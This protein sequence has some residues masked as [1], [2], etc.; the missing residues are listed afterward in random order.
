METNTC[1]VNH[2]DADAHLPPRKRLLAGLK[3]QNLD[4]HSPAPTSS[5]SLEDEYSDRLHNL[6][7]LHLN[8][9]SL[10]NEE[11]IEASRC[12][13]IKASEVAEA[14]RANAEQ[15]AEKAAKAMAAAKIALE[16][17]SRL[18]EEATKKERHQK[19]NKMKKQV[20]VQVFYNRNKRSTNCRTDEELARKL[21]QV[22]NSSPRIL[23]ASSDPESKNQ[24][25]KKLKTHNSAPLEERNQGSTAASIV[26][27]IEKVGTKG[28][29]DAVDL[30]A[31]KHDEDKK[32]SQPGSPLCKPD[33]VKLGNGAAVSPKDKYTAESPD[34]AGK[35]RGRMK[36]KKL[37]LSICNFRDK[38][39]PK[40]EL[41]PLG[42]GCTN[43]TTTVNQSS[44]VTSG[45][46]LMAVERTTS[47]KCQAF[48]P[49]PCVAQS[50]VMQS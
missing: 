39:S 8:D 24:K 40:R 10:S 46:S 32:A 48:N 50:K 18:S 29:I 31:L 15:K 9:P 41:K 33:R 17:V 5:C 16:L 42:E 23:K 34:S 27:G 19:K 36:Q 47:W 6:L 44:L 1:N 38:S 45:D 14:K 37:P 12:A 4:S 25:H 26:N 43:H 20:S 35:K 30:N 11:I 13:A 28:S 49:L 21:H 22:I 7:R 3:R 2:L